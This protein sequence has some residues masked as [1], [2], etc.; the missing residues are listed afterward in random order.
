MN[1]ATPKGKHKLSVDQVKLSSA[2][3]R[4]LQV[5]FDFKTLFTGVHRDPEYYKPRTHI[6]KLRRNPDSDDIP[7]IVIP[8]II[9]K[10]M[11]QDFD[12]DLNKL[13]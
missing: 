7:T 6:V 12:F 9:A 3:H 11:R 1:S 13:Y 2:P 5:Y 10:P 4:V 8:S